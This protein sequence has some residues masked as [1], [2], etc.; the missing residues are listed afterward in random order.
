MYDSET[1]LSKIGRIMDVSAV[2]TDVIMEEINQMISIVKSFHC[3][4]ASP[5]PWATRYTLEQLKDTPD[6][7][8]TGVVGFPAGAE[9]TF[10]KVATAK[11][12]IS[13][14]CRE[15]DMV[16]NVSA[17]K[18]GQY[19]FVERDIE[20]VVNAANGVPVKAILEIC[21]LTD[22]EIKRA[23]EIGVKAGATFIKTGTGWGQKPTTVDTIKL[24]RTTIGSAAKIK[25]AGGVRDLDTLLA[26]KAAG[27][28]RFGIGVRS[29]LAILKDAYTRASIPIPE[30]AEI[31]NENDTY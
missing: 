23:S 11:E 8:V 4:C 28:D 22:D 16:I 1:D 10:I 6:T 7:V 5:M 30:L 26:M 15:L 12:M 2:R 27:C 14:G 17:L 9:T 31:V 24:I 18:S 20:A 21:Y 29:A 25:A 13:L 3:V 19:Q